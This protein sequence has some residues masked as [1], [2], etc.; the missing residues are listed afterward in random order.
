[1]N[2]IQQLEQEEMNR[3]GRKMPEF[4]AGDTVI[5]LSLIHI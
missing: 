1:M 5:V 2:V 4:V 3:L